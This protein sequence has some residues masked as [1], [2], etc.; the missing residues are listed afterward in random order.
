MRF[1]ARAAVLPRVLVAIM[2]A[3][4]MAAGL[5]VGGAPPASASLGGPPGPPLCVQAALPLING[6][7]S[8]QN[9]WNTG[10]PIVGICDGTVYLSGSLTQPTSGSSEFA[11]LPS[12]ALPASNDYL[13]VYTYQG[14]AGVVRIDTSGAMY[15]YHG[16][17]AQFTSLAGISFPAAGTAMTPLTPLDN[18]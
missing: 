16:K 2:A 6:W 13:S 10:T 4:V 17:A 7:Q 8:A 18:G 3:L 12:W 5:A 9:L 1:I 14:T 11:V 15:A